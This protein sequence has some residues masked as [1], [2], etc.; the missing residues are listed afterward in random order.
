M[1]YERF[2]NASRPPPP[3]ACVP[4]ICRNQFATTL[5]VAKVRKSLAPLIHSVESSAYGHVAAV[6]RNVC[7]QL[8]EELC[9]GSR[10]AYPLVAHQQ[11]AQ[12][13]C[14]GARHSN[15]EQRPCEGLGGSVR[16]SQI[17]GL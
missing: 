8:R 4:S 10:N 12:E 7:L 13:L 6:V 15:D 9:L 5:R 11:L 16:G 1:S 3:A 2:E 14:S 17:H